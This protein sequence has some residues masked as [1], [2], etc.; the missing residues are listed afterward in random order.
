[1]LKGRRDSDANAT[2]QIKNMGTSTVDLR[3]TDT[4]Q[5]EMLKV[6]RHKVNAKGRMIG[7]API[8]D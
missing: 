8:F 4:T 1:V 6:T 2:E 7:G 5:P 3:M